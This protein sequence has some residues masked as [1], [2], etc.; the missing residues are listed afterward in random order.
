MSHRGGDGHAGRAT[1]RDDLGRIGTPAAGWGSDR[2]RDRGGAAGAA[3]ANR[4]SALGGFAARTAATEGAAD[5]VARRVLTG[6][7]GDPDQACLSGPRGLCAPEPDPTAPYTQ[8]PVCRR[9]P[10][11]YVR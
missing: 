8:Q 7:D 10:G 6:F 9:A 11:V 2:G 4:T 1:P 5:I 3:R